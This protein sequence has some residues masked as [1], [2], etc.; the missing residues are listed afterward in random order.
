MYIQDIAKMPERDQTVVGERGLM[1]SG[2]QKSRIFLA[3]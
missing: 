1:L 3:R 2:G